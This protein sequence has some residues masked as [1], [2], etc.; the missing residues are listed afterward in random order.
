[1]SGDLSLVREYAGRILFQASREGSQAVI[2]SFVSADQADDPLRLER[3]VVLHLCEEG[4]I[5]P[6]ET[7][8]SARTAIR[9]T[10]LEKHV[11][12]P[13]FIAPI[14]NEDYVRGS[15]EHLSLADLR[16]SYVVLNFWATWCRPCIDKHEDMVSLANRYEGMGVRVIGVLH[17]DDAARALAWLGDHPP[18]YY[19]TVV[20][21][22]G[23]VASAYGVR[24]IPRTYLIDPRGVVLD[25]VM[26]LEPERLARTLDELV[27]VA[28]ATGT[29]RD[30]G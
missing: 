13:G 29:S 11:P 24:G 1:M 2:E 30:D 3:L 16:G 18:G 22:G 10:G 25:N 21:E 26:V 12:A 15:K 17:R 20:D 4:P 5:A 19:Q 14:L 8:D 28:P 7:V 23:R 6:R 9:I 27:A